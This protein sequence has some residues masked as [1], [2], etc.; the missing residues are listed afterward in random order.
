MPNLLGVLDV[1]KHAR[2]RDRKS[3]SNLTI[4]ELMS[5]EYGGMNWGALAVY[6]CIANCVEGR[7]DYVIVQDSIDGTPEKRVGATDDAMVSD[8]DK[9]QEKCFDDDMTDD[10]DESE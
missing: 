2:K 6:T 1:D 4:D 10:G 9:K 3:T 5:R 8:A 7:E